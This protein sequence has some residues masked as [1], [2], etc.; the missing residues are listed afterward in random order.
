MRKI[1]SF[2][3]SLL[4]RPKTSFSE[5]TQ[6]KNNFLSV[7]NVAYIES[8]YEQWLNDKKSVSPSLSAYFEL[9]ERGEDP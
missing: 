9:L 6:F 5:F 3:K 1:L 8:M 7:T 2:S 4:I